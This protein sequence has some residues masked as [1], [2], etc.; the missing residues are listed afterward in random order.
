[1]LIIR[2]EVGVRGGGGQWGKILP[3]RL[4]LV[5]F[6]FLRH[7]VLFEW[8]EGEPVGMLVVALLDGVEEEGQGHPDQH[9][10]QEDEQGDY[11]HAP[12]G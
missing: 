6:C 11:V 9:E 12:T 2:G 8:Q 5:S 10:T 1:M 3:N 7:F 4:L